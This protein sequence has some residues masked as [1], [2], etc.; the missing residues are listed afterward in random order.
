MTASGLFR[1]SLACA[2]VLGGGVLAGPAQ[3]KDQGHGIVHMHGEIL[4]TACNVDTSSR[5]QTIDMLSQ[6]VSDIVSHDAGQER[7]FSIRL[8]NC[9][10]TRVSPNNKPLNDWSKFQIT[11]EGA[12]DH[13][14][15][16]VDGDARGVALQIRDDIGNVAIPG[17][18]MPVGTLMP[19]NMQLNYTLR[20]IGDG[21]VLLAGTYHT[22]IR[23]KLD[24][25]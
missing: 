19:G 6:P 24:Y 18:P 9:V 22:T 4:D 21:E 2:I 3:A 13:D 12:H 14:A 7:P 5:D 20:L 25:Y 10:L 11:F 16:G 15:F 17:E 1:R 8:V 23:Y